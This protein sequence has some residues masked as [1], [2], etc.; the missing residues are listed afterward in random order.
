MMLLPIG[1][2]GRKR[3]MKEG[4][5]EQWEDRREEG[6]FDPSTCSEQAS[7]IRSALGHEL[8]PNGAQDRQETEDSRLR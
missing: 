2:A 5:R 3:Q 6:P 8:G 7:S 1:S 4:E